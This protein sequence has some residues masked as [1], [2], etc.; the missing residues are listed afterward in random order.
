MVGP[1]VPG[2]SLD[3][4]IV[5]GE[6]AMTVNLDV[7]VDIDSGQRFS[8]HSQLLP[9]EHRIEYVARHSVGRW[10]E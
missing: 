1:E 5:Q 3:Q 9:L 10:R 2:G 7:H 4:L 8:P 6:M